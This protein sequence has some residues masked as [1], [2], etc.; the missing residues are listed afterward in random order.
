MD[1]ALL[2]CLNHLATAAARIKKNN[3]VLKAGETLDPP[4]DQGFVRPKVTFH[5][6]VDWLGENCSLS[7]AHVPSCVFAFSY[8]AALVALLIHMEEVES[9]SFAWC[10]C[11]GGKA[12]RPWL[13]L[14]IL[15]L[16]IPS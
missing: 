9:H 10:S 13:G 8:P 1:A 2:H 11:D 16:L 5:T 7:S 12:N 4:R 3:D 15:D 6:F 14:A